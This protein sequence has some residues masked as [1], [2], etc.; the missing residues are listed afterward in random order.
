MRNRLSYIWRKIIP[1][2]RINEKRSFSQCGE[3]LILDF[4]F[5]ELGISKPSYLDIGAHHPKYLNNTYLFYLN[6]SRGINIEP[7]PALFSEFGKTRSGDINL[8]IGIGEKETEA[9][10]YIMTEPTLNT[11]VKEEAERIEREQ[12]FYKIKEVRKIRLRAVTDVIREYRNGIFPDF[13]SLDVEGL[14]EMILRSI[15]FKINAP[16]VICVETLTFAANRTGQK[17]EDLIRFVSEMGYMIY[18]DTH[19]NTIFVRKEIWEK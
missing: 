12:S 10:F 18:A 4:L 14:D 11:F 19:I 7:D 15:D 13:M 5:R 16:K 17:K 6:G 3:D 8:N 1:P 9:D 2:G